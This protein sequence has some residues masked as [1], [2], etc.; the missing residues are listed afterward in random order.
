MDVINYLLLGFENSLTPSNLYLCLLGCLIGTLIGVLPGLGPTTT[1]SLLLPL[2]YGLGP[3]PSIAMLAGIYY[4]AQYGGSTTAILLKTPG[5]ISSLMTCIDGYRMTQKGQAG[6]AIFAAGIA[7]FIAGIVTII[8]MI[9]FSIPFSELALKFGP[10]EFCSLIL[11]GLVGVS[12]LTQGNIIK[13]FGMACIGI[14][15][16]TIG[17]DPNTSVE[18]FTFNWPDLL[19]GVGF[20]VVAVGLFGIAESIKNLIHTRENQLYKGK[21]KLW[22][23]WL[24]IKRIIPSSLRGTAIGATIG[25]MPG[26]GASSSTFAAYMCEKH[27][28]KKAKLGSGAIEG[29]AAPEAANNACAQSGYIPLLMLGIPENSVMALML[30]ALIINGVHPGP[31]LMLQQ[32]EIF[33]SITTSMIIGNLF[34]LIL[35][36]PLVTIWI[37]IIRISK[38]I[39]YP[40]ILILCAI[41]VYSIKNNINDVYI[42]IFFGLLGLFFIWTKLEP[43]P[44]MLGL[45]LGPMLETYFRRQM[46]LSHSSWKPFID[47]PISAVILTILLFLLVYGI[48]K[49]FKNKSTK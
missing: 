11:L 48:F 34:L 39:L 4:G 30:G 31:N 44:L 12:V 14:L 33:W 20:A 37:K 17:S 15:I 22:P 21:I 35:N 7:S 2:T 28:N 45:V 46:I 5:E 13:G 16:G 41:G 1:I 40:I 42:A 8:F 3:I 29:V 18:R 32:P 19:D 9:F 49:L 36:V 27:L 6:I 43:A 25:L 47:R 10:A 26:G 24:N 23:T 38:R